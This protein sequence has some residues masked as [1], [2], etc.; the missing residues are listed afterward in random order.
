MNIKKI[1]FMLLASV[2]LAA[3]AVTSCTTNDNPVSQTDEQSDGDILTPPTEDVVLTQLSLP[4]AFLGSE[5]SKIIQLLQKR[6]SNVTTTVNEDTKVIMIN[7]D[8][9]GTFSDEEKQQ[10]RDAY[11]RNAFFVVH[12][13]LKEIVNS[14]YNDIQRDIEDTDDSDVMS[15]DDFNLVG[16]NKHGDRFFLEHLLPNNHTETSYILDDDEGAEEQIVTEETEPKMP[17]EHTIG[18]CAEAFVQMLNRA[19]AQHSQT[20]AS[21][22]G[23]MAPCITY[24][25][26]WSIGAEK[27]KGVKYPAAQAVLSSL[28]YVESA[29]NF[30]TSNPENGDDFYCVKIDNTFPANKFFVVENV[31]KPEK[32]LYYNHWGYTAIENIS[33]YTWDINQGS[34]QMVQSSPQTTTEQGNV[35]TTTGFDIGA[36]V[37]GGWASGDGVNVGGSFSFGYSSSTAESWDISDVTVKQED[38]ISASANGASIYKWH[39]N[40]TEPYYNNN[41]GKGT[42]CHVPPIGRSTIH[43]TQSMLI[44]VPKSRSNTSS[45]TLTANIYNKIR[46]IAHQRYYKTKSDNRKDKEYSYSFTIPLSNYAPDRYIGNYRVKCTDIADPTEYE[47]KEFT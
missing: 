9:I 39:Y 20:R 6:C 10:L 42:I 15:L 5:Q 2:M 47:S 40:L 12:K 23:S 26:T 1:K 36:S 7:T 3:T 17:S 35:S 11:D 46:T 27:W 21:S 8:L 43:Y 41:G 28:V 32:A 44:R 4:T 24:T 45:M 38:D 34:V 31:Y 19:Y 14:F 29:Y 30:S 22:S 18:L 13:P 25:S 37:D 33:Q 16:F